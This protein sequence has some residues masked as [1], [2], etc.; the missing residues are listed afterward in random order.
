MSATASPSEACGA[1]VPLGQ[2]QPQLAQMRLARLEARDERIGLLDALGGHPVSVRTDIWQ[3]AA[4]RLDNGGLGRQPRLRGTAQ[5][6]H[7]ALPRP[8]K[9]VFGWDQGLTP[10]P[11]LLTHTHALTYECR[12]AN[13]SH[14]HC[15]CS[16]RSIKDALTHTHGDTDG[17]QTLCPMRGQ[18]RRRGGGR[19]EP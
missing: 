7:Q 9:D 16:G 10:R 6:T 3:H 14:R 8:G 15:Y 5:K 1:L 18:A 11:A 17:E 19:G 2:E 13:G 12:G 4:S